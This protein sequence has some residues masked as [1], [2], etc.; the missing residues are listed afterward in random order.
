MWWTSPFWLL[1]LILI[2]PIIRM[3]N[4]P[5]PR[6][7]SHDLVTT[8][9]P[10][11]AGRDR[12]LTRLTWL[13]VL[14][15]LATVLALAGTTVILPSNQ[16]QLIVLLD[17]SSS[18]DLSQIERAR[19]TALHLI[20]QLKPKDR[21]AVASFAGEPQL[22]A[23]FDTP[24][25]AVAILAGADLGASGTGATNIEAA[26]RL[27]KELLTEIHG[28]RRILLFT[29]GHPTAGG[30][31][32][33]VL[34]S[35]KGIPVDVIPIG[36]TNAGLFTRGLELPE[37]VH[38]DEPVL[39]HWKVETDRARNISL[40]VKVAD[41]P[42]IKKL[43]KVMPGRTWVPL[44]LP[45][46]KPGTYRVTV[47]AVGDQGEPF[48]GA[49]TGGVLQVKGPGRVLVI[50]GGASRSPVGEALQTQGM[51]VEFGNI[52]DLPE[53]VLGLTGYGAMVLDNVPA[54]YL[55]EDQQSAIQSYVSSGGGLLV[56]GGDSSLG[57]GEYYA[58]GLEDLLPVQTDTRQRLLFTR[59]NILFVIDHSGSMSEMV[60][61]T[62][63]QLAAMQGVMGAI[64]EL[65]PIDEVGILAFDTTPTWVLP[66]TPVSRQT[67]IQRSLS[68][69]GQGGGTDISTALEEIVNGFR[70][71]G[72]VRRHTII[73][74]DGQ[75]TSSANFKQLIDGIK[76]AG[77]SV[78]TIGI[79]EE[80]NEELL[81]N[82]A[83]WGEGQ[84]YRADLDQIP[85]V[86]LKET[87]RVTRDLIQEGSFRPKVRTQAPVLTGL[88]RGLPS[89]NGYLI[90]KPKTLA[91]VYLETGK[92]DPLLAS[93]RY[94]SG[95]V[96]VFTSDSG[97]RWLSEWSGTGY[98]NLLWSQLI[99]TIERGSSDTGL[100]VDTKV[101]AGNALIEVEA[102]GSDRRL[103]TGLQLIGRAENSGETFKLHET[104]PGHYQALVALEGNGLQTFQIYDRLGNDLAIGW[105]WNQQG[106]GLQSP[107]PDL[108]FLG[109]LAST[110]GGKVFSSAVKALPGANWAWKQTLLPNYLII[111]ALLLFVI[112]L[113]Y[114]STSL[115]QMR[116]A[117]ALVDTWWA[118]QARL[119]DL[120][121]GFASRDHY[122]DAERQ[123]VNE[124]YR[125][126][127][128]RVHR[129]KEAV[130]KD[131]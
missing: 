48:P 94:G 28:N 123:R 21:V 118:A 38:P 2:I 37:N 66:F 85:K 32:K 49:H 65:N 13:R 29:D 6:R 77:V 88:D 103:R 11:H 25:N 15:V 69:I 57:R 19:S 8:A 42:V 58:T 56:V 116:M 18:I 60:G 112:E 106:E 53:T 105:A 99:R 10:S 93:W 75:T 50:N 3:G 130:E 127:A 89:V 83:A 26:L 92:D 68:E 9:D 46:R 51:K 63:K 122:G 73:L 128:E 115:G 109:Q 52:E 22:I 39:A 126:L 72:P 78:T 59:A 41:R 14:T 90:T 102:L 27:G 95:Q 129:N 61:N 45:G 119:V 100:R 24:A 117:Q 121:H 34:Q 79:G 40:V 1:G 16:R 101:E 96:A 125:Y 44:N 108:L 86:I 17:V 81:R 71:R 91:T 67:L 55:T 35:M 31:L 12:N 54:L 76:S 98:Y 87:V 62:S 36:R 80:I 104:A 43:I 23:P 114:R 64:G 110:S 124:A 82:I 47:E 5:L 84:F 97:S 120:M 131:A 33:V 70:D 7:S 20:G 111:L 74:T 4:L 107:E 30:P 113:G